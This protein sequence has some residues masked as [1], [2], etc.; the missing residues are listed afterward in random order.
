MYSL[1]L[2][3]HVVENVRSGALAIIHVG[4]DAATLK[5]YVMGLGL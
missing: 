5:R 2:R 1:K 3:L 4:S